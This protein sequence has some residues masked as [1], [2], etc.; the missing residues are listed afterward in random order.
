MG[1]GR[2]FSD[3][4]SLGARVEPYVEGTWGED[5]MKKIRLNLSQKRNRFLARV[6]VQYV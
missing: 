4:R 2:L 3:F 6:H 5:E 1:S